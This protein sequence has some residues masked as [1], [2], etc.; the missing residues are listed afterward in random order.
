MKVCLVMTVILSYCAIHKLVC[1]SWKIKHLFQ[2]LVAKVVD[3]LSSTCKGNFFMNT[4]H[5]MFFKN[6]GLDSS[7]VFGIQR[8]HGPG[9][10]KKSKWFPRNTNQR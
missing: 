10:I 6:L 2:R 3:L 1:F 7:L 5:E 9:K 4:L 8:I